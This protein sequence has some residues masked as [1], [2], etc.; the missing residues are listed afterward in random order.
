MIDKEKLRQAIPVLDGHADTW[1]L[2]RDY[3]TLQEVAAELSQPFGG[4][5]DCVV[6]AEARGFALG[7]AVAIQLQVGFVPVRKDQSFLPGVCLEALS[8]PD[9]KGARHSLR[10]Q[11]HALEKK[12]RILLVDDWV[13]TGSQALCIKELIQAAGAELSGVACIVDQSSAEVKKKLG[14][15]KSLITNQELY[16]ERSQ[17]DYLK[18]RMPEQV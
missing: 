13:D 1:G 10:I 9:Y 6:G 16:G 4:K 5:V 7:M 12:A 11:S 18:G 17:F 15:F 2:L 14:L 3:I 8:Q